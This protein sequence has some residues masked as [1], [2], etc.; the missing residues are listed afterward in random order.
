MTLGLRSFALL[1]ILVLACAC[2]AGAQPLVSP[3]SSKPFRLRMDVQLA[4]IPVHV[5]NQ[6]G[7]TI[8]GLRPA[9]FRVFDDGVEQKITYFM[10]EEAPVSVGFLLDISQSMKDKMAKSLL[11]AGEFLRS[12]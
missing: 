2:L 4:L 5:T 10:N 1:C 7:A 3:D 12:S 9:S 11:A 6:Q 8:L